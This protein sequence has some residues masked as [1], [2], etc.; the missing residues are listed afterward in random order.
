MNYL[1]I[2]SVIPNK[3]N[4]G[5]KIL[6]N[7][8][9]S[10]NPSIDT[11]NM[12]LEEIFY[13][14]SQSFINNSTH[15]ILILDEGNRII[16]KHFLEAKQKLLR[17]IIKIYFNKPES[18]HL[19]LNSYKLFQIKIEIMN[20]SQISNHKIYDYN[21]IKNLNDFNDLNNL[22]KDNKKLKEEIYNI[23]TK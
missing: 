14:Q 17:E 12:L 4:Y 18:N 1:T 5:L 15:N 3:I 9:N 10:L 23:Y 22:I 8:I 2:T 11:I 21:T 13:F 16:I 19:L 20:D 6:L 7:I